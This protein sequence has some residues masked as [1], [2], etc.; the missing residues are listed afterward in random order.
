[1]TRLVAP[2]HRVAA[3][4]AVIIHRLSGMIS[5]VKLTSV[6][7]VINIRSPAQRADHLL[8]QRRDGTADVAA[9]WYL[10]VVTVLSLG[11]TSSGGVS[12]PG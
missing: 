6:A 2:A 12:R 1:M 7:S 11:R 9:I 5:M 4:D 3:G 8:R 10:A